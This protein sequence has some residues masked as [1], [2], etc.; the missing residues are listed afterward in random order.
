MSIQAAGPAVVSS[1]PVVG[2]ATVG[3]QVE[4]AGSASIVSGAAQITDT[5]TAPIGAPVVLVR[6]EDGLFRPDAATAAKAAW[7][8]P[9]RWRRGQPTDDPAAPEG[10][11]FIDTTTGRGY[12]RREV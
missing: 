12:R 10:A 2:Q 4:A 1:G 7:S 3:G 6:G 11:V 5:G 8:D 9:V